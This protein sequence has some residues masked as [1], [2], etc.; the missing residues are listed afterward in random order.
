MADDTLSR[1]GGIKAEML[2]VWGRQDPHIPREGRR[3]IYDTL[4]DTGVN[5][6]WHEFNG[7]HAFLRDEGPRYDPEL[8]GLTW[9]LIL[10]MLHR[11]LHRV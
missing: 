11:C 8:A 2:Y 6:T 10:S 9:N 3:L 5:F 7:Q 1:L 4:T